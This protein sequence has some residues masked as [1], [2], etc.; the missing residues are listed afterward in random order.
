MNK[1]ISLEVASKMQD[2]MTLNTFRGDLKSV[3]QSQWKLLGGMLLSFIE[4]RHVYDFVL[5]S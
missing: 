3:S 4:L 5:L 1:V 2:T